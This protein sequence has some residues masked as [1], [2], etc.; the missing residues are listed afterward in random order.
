MSRTWRPGEFVCKSQ[1]YVYL[2]SLAGDIA[3][4]GTPQDIGLPAQIA[5]WI[6][7]IIGFLATVGVTIYI[8]RIAKKALT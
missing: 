4:L 7:R 1:T 2:G 3:L 8:T 6:V 5:Q